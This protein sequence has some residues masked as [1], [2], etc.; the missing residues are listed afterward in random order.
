MICSTGEKKRWE[1]QGRK[2]KQE[3]ERKN[4]IGLVLVPLTQMQEDVETRS[5]MVMMKMGMMVTWTMVAFIL[6]LYDGFAP[7]SYV[8]ARCLVM[9][10]CRL[11]A[12][13]KI[14]PCG[15]AKTK[16]AVG[17]VSSLNC[18]NMIMFFLSDSIHRCDTCTYLTIWIWNCAVLL[19]E[20]WLFYIFRSS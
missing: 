8:P 7:Q 6:W 10:V 17:N 14:P 20:I 5:V 19:V 9:H 12:T 15:G 2:I 1:S 11:W 16:S 3:S 18:K 13:L 4:Q